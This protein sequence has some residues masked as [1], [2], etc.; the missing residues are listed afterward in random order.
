MAYAK[1]CGVADVD[2]P[3]C[4]LQHLGAEGVKDEE[5]LAVVLR[6]GYGVQNV[7]E[8]SDSILSKHALSHLI[9]MDLQ[10]LRGIKGISKGKA[11]V[12]AASFELA[13]RGL[14]QGIGI[15]PS[16]SSP[17]DAVDLLTD[18]KD[19]MKEHFV[20][21][22]LNARN[23][24]I[25]RETICV[26][27]LNSALVHPREVFLPAV[28]SSSASMIVAHNHPSGDVTPSRE[29]IELTRRLVQVGEILGIE[30]L[31]HIIV[32]SQRFISMK[33]ANIF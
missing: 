15:L 20:A 24:V 27:S 6:T 30:V 1:I 21:L 8:L 5:L 18:I 2:L 31:D 28:G 22:Y 13:R 26:G 11:E 29:D 17:S 33:E 10:A 4:K 23:Q 7:L 16:I 3:W 25:N 12:L 9:G 32:G 19:A 14:N